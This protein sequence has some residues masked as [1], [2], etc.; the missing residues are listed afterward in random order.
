MLS[1][2]NAM[3]RA[4]I[5][6]LVQQ[7]ALTAGLASGPLFRCPPVEG[8][9]QRGV[10]RVRTLPHPPAEKR[11]SLHFVVPSLPF[12]IHACLSPNAHLSAIPSACV[13]ASLEAECALWGFWF[14]QKC[15]RHPRKA[16]CVFFSF[17]AFFPCLNIPFASSSS[18]PML[19]V[20]E[21]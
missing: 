17:F 13:S 2:Y 14:P 12:G 16:Q 8:W 6:A 15:S 11:I 9:I 5:V 1:L 20:S 7:Q 10:L 4:F 18:T 21:G 19:H 3:Q